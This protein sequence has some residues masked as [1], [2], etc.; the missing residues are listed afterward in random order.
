MNRF[1]LYASLLS[2]VLLPSCV[3]STPKGQMDLATCVADR[4]KPISELGREKLLPDLTQTRRVEL[5]Q[6]KQLANGMP[7]REK[8]RL[9]NITRE[10][11]LRQHGREL[12][13]Q[14]Y[15][16]L[17]DDIYDAFTQNAARLYRATDCGSAED[18]GSQSFVVFTDWLMSAYG[19]PDTWQRL[20][21][22]PENRDDAPPRFDIASVVRTAV[23]LEVN[24]VPY[25]LSQLIGAFRR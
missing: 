14:A 22:M 6:I 24:G 12:T 1:V 9:L 19:P 11:R 10:V 20:L 8:K 4:M 17:H 13:S 16:Q 23:V 2:C 15:L 5:G 18:V 7:S 25:Q 3:T 21:L